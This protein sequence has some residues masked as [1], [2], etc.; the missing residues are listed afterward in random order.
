MYVCMYSMYV[1]MYVYTQMYA[2]VY[3]VKLMTCAVSPFG[4]IGG[5]KLSLSLSQWDGSAR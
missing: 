2:C 3:C 4:C 1:C 5:W